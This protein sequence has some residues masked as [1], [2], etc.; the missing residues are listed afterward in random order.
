[1]DVVWNALR[2]KTFNE[3]VHFEHFF[4]AFLGTFFEDEADLVKQVMRKLDPTRTGY[5][6]PDNFLKFH[7]PARTNDL[8]RLLQRLEL[9]DVK[10]HFSGRNGR[11]SEDITWGAFNDYYFVVYACLKDVKMFA[12]LIA[13]TWGVMRD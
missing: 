9:P 6:I 7:K 4:N 13:E 1:M 3:E 10:E 12:K 11:I 2:D 5:A 8:Y